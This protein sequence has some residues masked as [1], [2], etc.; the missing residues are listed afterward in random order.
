MKK[1]QF[2]VELVTEYAKDLVYE[3]QYDILK[4]DQLFV[5]ANQNKRIQSIVESNEHIDYVIVDSP[6]LLSKIYAI[7]NQYPKDFISF[8]EFCVDLFCSYENINLFLDR[9]NIPY[10]A[11]G[12]VQKT[13]EEA[14]KIDIA[15]KAELNYWKIPYTII[16]DKTINAE[17]LNMIGIN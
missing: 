11:E 8:G 13:I 9:T 5:L 4:N 3:K 6:L 2:N 12:R 16:K 17:F 10:N 15:I 7:I 14:E 1:Q